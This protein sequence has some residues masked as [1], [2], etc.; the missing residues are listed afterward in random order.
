MSYNE[1]GDMIAEKGQ[2]FRQ[3]GWQINGGEFDGRLVRLD[4]EETLEKMKTAPHG[5]I[6][7]IY[8]EVGTD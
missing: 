2:T 6:S 8:V 3:V 1:N 4:A 5:S 7:P